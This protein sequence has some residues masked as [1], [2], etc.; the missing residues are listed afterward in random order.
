MSVNIH[1]KNGVGPW[2]QEYVPYAL[3]VGI[4]P[5]S[6][7]TVPFNLSNSTWAYALED[8]VIKPRSEEGI[9][10]WWNDGTG[11]A[12]AGLTGQKQNPDIWS[13]YLTM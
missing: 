1:D 12:Q 13:D 4:D 2:E 10:F 9:D 8:I 5:L 3:A 7:A 6:Q 11:G